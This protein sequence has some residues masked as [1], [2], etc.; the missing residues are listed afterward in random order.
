[1][2]AVSTSG[3]IP[4]ERPESKV[5]RKNY[6]KITKIITS[7]GLTRQ[8]ACRLTEEDFIVSSGIFRAVGA[9]DS[10][11]VIQMLEAVQ[12][13]LE[14]TDSPEEMLKQFITI[15]DDVPLRELA[16][17]ITSSYGKQNYHSL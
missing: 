11:Q 5:I 14:T 9:S 7:Q 15:L 12:C 16:R 2:H 8:F 4:K 3:V 10:D 1:M 17:Q 13:M 6:V